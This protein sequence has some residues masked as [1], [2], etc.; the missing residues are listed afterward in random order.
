MS[1]IEAVSADVVGR[2]LEHVDD[3]LAVVDD[4]GTIV[5]ATGRFASMF[6][7]TPDELVGLAVEVL[8]PPD[9]VHDHV[10]ARER[11][12]RE[13]RSR[14]MA[15]PGYDIEGLR[16]DATR[17]P[18]DVQLSPLTDGLVLVVV[19]DATDARAR[20]AE[21][22]L[23]RADLAAT[24]LREAANGEALDAVVQQ[25]FGAT[26]QLHAVRQHAPDAVAAALDR[27]IA[28]L[29]HALDVATSANSTTT[30]VP[31]DRPAP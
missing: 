15:A 10:A 29:H 13:G 25:V 6:G 16:H 7:Y 24:R 4:T 12:V 9:A 22:A 3:G 8:V 18:V 14:P 1:A 20:A 23:T 5:L 26:A 2:A 11:F 31:V 17:I 27:C 30:R 19:R 28:V 21:L